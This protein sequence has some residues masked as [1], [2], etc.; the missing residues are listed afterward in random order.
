MVVYKSYFV[1]DKAYKWFLWNVEMVWVTINIDLYKT[2]I[3]LIHSLRITQQNLELFNN[4][5]YSSNPYL[6]S[7]LHPTY[8]FIVHNFRIKLKCISWM[9]GTVSTKNEMLLKM[10]YCV[11]EYFGWNIWILLLRSW[12]YF[13]IH[14]ITFFW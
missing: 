3:H 5:K 13:I 10:H 12:L 7:F 6:I 11:L 4:S 9:K 8:L 14:L 2:W 1:D